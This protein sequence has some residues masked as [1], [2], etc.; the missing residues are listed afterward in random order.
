MAHVAC[1][2]AGP[3][4]SSRSSAWRAA[5]DRALYSVLELELSSRLV[6]ETTDA[7]WPLVGTDLADVLSV[8]EAAG[9]HWTYWIWRRPFAEN[10]HAGWDCGGFAVVCQQAEGAAYQINELLM[11]ALAQRIR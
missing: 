10:E 1:R 9:L 8:F 6:P 7:Y 2:F 3:V 5:P 11:S 4:R